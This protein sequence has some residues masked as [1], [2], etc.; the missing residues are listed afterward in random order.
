M[1]RWISSRS[2]SPYPGVQSKYWGQRYRF[3]SL[4]DRGVR[5]DPEGW[6]SVT[7][8]C[9][10]KHIAERCRCD[11]AVDPFVGCG[12]NAIQLAMTCHLV[13]AIDIDPIKLHHARHNA[14][15]YGV[16]DR[17]EFILGDAMSVLPTVK[18]DVVFLSPPWGGPAYSESPFFDLDTMIP[19][20]LSA[21]GVFKAAQGVTPNVAFFL[22]RNVDAKQVATISC[23][24]NPSHS[25]EVE[26]RGLL[27]E[28]Q[29]ELEHQFL[30]GKL[31]TTTA[32][33][34]ELF[35]A[36]SAGGQ[37][38]CA[39]AGSGLGSSD[40][41]E[42]EEDEGGGDGSGQG[43]GEG[44]G[45]S[46][47]AIDEARKKEGPG[48]A[49][50]NPSVIPGRSDSLKP[51]TAWASSEWCG[52]RIHFDNDGECY[53]ERRERGGEGVIMS[54]SQCAPGSQHDE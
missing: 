4:Y 16:E 44:R 5:L 20:P 30:N 33:F 45:S 11:V 29:C 52:S 51:K 1:V 13:I 9:I 10:S 15:I 12:G 2:R 42:W 31:K 48:S 40:E 37:G 3:F 25:S 26:R 39:R 14:S 27:G 28:E 8:E 6:F 50:P 36:A 49:V 24:P 7:P 46:C 34:G 23:D 41:G 32:Y 19:A 53:N 38:G 47:G 35:R 22:P 18:A 21:R 17:I 43:Y 54:S